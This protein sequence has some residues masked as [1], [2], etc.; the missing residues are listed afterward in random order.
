MKELMNLR[1]ALNTLNSREKECL[2]LRYGLDTDNKI[3]KYKEVSEI[4]GVSK[5]RCG[6]I[7]KKAIRKL[8]HPSRAFL[9]IEEILNERLKADIFKYYRNKYSL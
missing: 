6:Q 7:V 8:C 5:T 2:I 9:L 4:I 3:M 1:L